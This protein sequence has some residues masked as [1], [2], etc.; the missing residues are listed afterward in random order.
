MIIQNSMSAFQ[1][2]ISGRRWR[3]NGAILLVAI[4]LAVGATAKEEPV[5]SAF[6]KYCGLDENPKGTLCLRMQ[7]GQLFWHGKLIRDADVGSYVAG[8]LKTTKP[9]VI[10]LFPAEKENF[11]DVVKNVAVLS[12]L[13]VQKVVIT[14]P[15]NDTQ[16]ERFT[17]DAK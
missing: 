16:F 14:P 5:E 10:G 3:S 2:K 12:K 8:V 13:D 1:S 7:D 9:R 4:L 15:I 17:K 11:G 6:V